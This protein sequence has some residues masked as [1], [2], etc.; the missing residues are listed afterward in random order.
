MKKKRFKSKRIKIELPDSI[1]SQIFTKLGLKDLVKTSTLSKLWRNEWHLRTG[2]N[3]DLC[4]MFD[5]N[6]ELPKSIPLLK[7]FQS[8]FATRLDQ[9]MLNYEGDMINSIRVKFPLTY[10]HSDIIERLIYKGIDKGVKSIE[11]L[12]SYE[13][14]DDTP[15]FASE[16]LPCHFS[17][18][19][20][21]YTDSLTY[22]HLQNCYLK[23]SMEFSGL[24]N[25]RTL[26]L[27]RVDLC[28]NRLEGLFSDCI[29]LVD[30]IL[31]GYK[32]WSNLEIISST[33]L[34]L[35]ILNCLIIT[36][37]KIDI[38]ASNLSS[39][40]Y[41]CFGDFFV[42]RMNIEAPILSKFSFRGCKIYKPVGFSG[43]K[44]VTTIVIDG[45]RQ[46]LQPTNIVSLLFSKCL[47]L[48]DVTF[49]NCMCIY[50]MNIVSSKLRHLKIIGCGFNRRIDIN[51]LNLAS[52]EYRGD[53]GRN[54]FVTAP[55]LLRVLW[56]AGETKINSH[57]FDPI[58]R[59][60]HIENLAMIISTSQV[61]KVTE[62]LVLYRNLRH[63]ELFIEGAYDPNMNFFWILD[64]A[65]A[66]P[67]LQKL[68]LTIRNVH[69]E[70]SH[71]VGFKRQRKEYAG[72]SHNE[73]KHVEL[74][75]CVC[76]DPTPIVTGARTSTSPASLIAVHL[77]NNKHV[78]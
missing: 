3:F 48:E 21:S 78:P 19:I 66:S 70:N 52:F 17:F 44:N 63:L 49:K 65:M 55:R 20:L 37:W 30:F 42:H 77:E 13:T 76:H 73:L 25:V 26:V 8:E 68:S 29:H 57:A 23:P 75:G 51:A 71:M 39:I 2:L 53:T 16:L 41:S 36:Q 22:L 58:I 59:L 34:R 43:L 38:N 12:F 4:N 10:E 24:K 32:F 67:R 74:R 60:Q 27:Q 14:N 1:I 7:G 35:N 6:Q 50:D 31:D 28:Q 5:H 46:I 9:F 64:I 18:D 15:R 61:A 72:F 56:N 11:L 69:L 47:Q 54:I 62:V 45:H 40:K 33:L